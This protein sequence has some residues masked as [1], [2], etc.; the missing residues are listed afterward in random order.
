MALYDIE[1]AILEVLADDAA[2]LSLGEM[3]HVR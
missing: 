3:R 1:N 2:M